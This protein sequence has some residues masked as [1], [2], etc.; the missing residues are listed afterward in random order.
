MR[1]S[2]SGLPAATPQ[3]QDEGVRKSAHPCSIDLCFWAVLSPRRKEKAVQICTTLWLRQKEIGEEID[4]K[5][6][7]NHTSASRQQ[8]EP[9]P[10]EDSVRW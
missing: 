7:E 6:V 8:P 5:Y 1:D 9:V 2:V 3:G 4:L 10:C